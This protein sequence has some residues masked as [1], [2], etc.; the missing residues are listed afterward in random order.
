MNRDG[1]LALD[2]KVTRLVLVALTTALSSCNW[3]HDVFEGFEWKFANVQPEVWEAIEGSDLLGTPGR[4]SASCGDRADDSTCTHLTMRVS[5][6]GGAQP[7]NW[8]VQIVAVAPETF[9][10]QIEEPSTS[11]RFQPDCLLCCSMLAGSSLFAPNDRPATITSGTWTSTPSG[12][13]SVRVAFDLTIEVP[14]VDPSD[15]EEFPEC[16]ATAF[17]FRVA[18]TIDGHRESVTHEDCAS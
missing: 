12:A 2:M 9:S 4:V 11:V 10:V 13:T 16:P 1:G 7:F 14:P 18:G 3:C 5:T 17:R 15:L 8:S 6:I